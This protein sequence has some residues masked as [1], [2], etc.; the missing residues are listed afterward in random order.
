[1]EGN[2]GK[3]D[4]DQTIEHECLLVYTLCLIFSSVISILNSFHL[5]KT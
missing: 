1:M 2:I 4:A 3:M 5:L